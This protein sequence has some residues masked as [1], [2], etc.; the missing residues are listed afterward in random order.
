MASTLFNFP[1]K[2]A[3]LVEQDL[4]VGLCPSAAA[5]VPKVGW[6]QHMPPKTG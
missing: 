5:I 6:L 2:A 1:L 3:D 4:D